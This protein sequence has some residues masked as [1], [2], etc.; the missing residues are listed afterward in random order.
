MAPS[1]ETPLDL[2]MHGTVVTVLRV[3]PPHVK[4][5][6]RSS[7][8]RHETSCL[9]NNTFHIKNH[10]TPQADLFDNGSQSWV[11]CSLQIMFETRGL[12][13]IHSS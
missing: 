9:S 13:L 2:D 5:C 3:A 7:T 6:V 12:H 1:T 8:T 11:S 4:V 10:T